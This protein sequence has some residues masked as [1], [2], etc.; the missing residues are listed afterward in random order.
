MEMKYYFGYNKVLNS[1]A[2]E[3]GAKHL[4]E[5][6]REESM[7]MDTLPNRYARYTGE[8]EENDYL[9]YCDYLR[10]SNGKI[11]LRMLEEEDGKQLIEL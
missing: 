3:T 5:K 2:A 10:A 11:V 8:L 9:T 7:P 1:V 4:I 6:I